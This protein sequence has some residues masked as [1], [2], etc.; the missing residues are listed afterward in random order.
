MGTT[1][2]STRTATHGGSDPHVPGANRANPRPPAVSD[3][4]PKAGIDASRTR[5]SE[6][7]IF[8]SPSAIARE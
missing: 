5:A 4:R 7:S 1:A 8:G 3:Q 6:G 2:H